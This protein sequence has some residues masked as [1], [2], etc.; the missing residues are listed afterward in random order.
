MFWDGGPAVGVVL[1]GVVP[2]DVVQF[3]LLVNVDEHLAA[4]RLA[5]AGAP[6][7]AWRLR[8]A[9]STR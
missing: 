7:L 3:L 4:D 6:D 1:G 2:G 8:M 9:T 5:D